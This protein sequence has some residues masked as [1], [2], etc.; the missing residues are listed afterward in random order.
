V[1]VR[2]NAP[3]DDAF[4]AAVRGKRRTGKVP[5]AVAAISKIS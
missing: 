1:F 2:I 4:L 5:K 3:Y